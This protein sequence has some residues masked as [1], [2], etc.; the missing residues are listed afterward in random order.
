MNGIATWFT[1]NMATTAS[2]SPP[3]LSRMENSAI[4]CQNNAT[5]LRRYQKPGSH[6]ACAGPCP[7]VVH[8]RPSVFQCQPQTSL[9]LPPF[10]GNPLWVAPRRRPMGYGAS[11]TSNSAGGWGGLAR[12]TRNARGKICYHEVY[13][14]PAGSRPRSS[15]GRM[16]ESLE[17]ERRPTATFPLLLSASPVLFLFFV[18]FVVKCCL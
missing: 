15:R 3:R 13:P 12:G 4:K 7:L 10:P 8:M 11:L 5:W 18:N 1:T 9:R 14:P 2:R 17:G 16:A 6:T